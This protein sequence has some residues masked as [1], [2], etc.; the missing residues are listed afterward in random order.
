MPH[1]LRVVFFVFLTSLDL[2]PPFSFSGLVM[3]M[4]RQVRNEIAQVV[5]AGIKEKAG[6]HEDAKS[7]AQRTVGQS[8]K[9]SWTARKSKMRK[10]KKKQSG[11]RKT[12]WKCNG[13]KMR[14]WKSFWSKEGRN[15]VS[16]RRKSCKK[17][18]ELVVRERMSQGE[19]VKSLKKKEESERIVL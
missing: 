3:W 11:K 19:G 13:R 14:S 17:A 7:T 15:E 9:Q 18:P 10:R 4:S 12:R 16:C 8:V 6:V 5:D 1:C 2:L